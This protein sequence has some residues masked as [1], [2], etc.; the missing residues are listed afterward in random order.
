MVELHGWITFRETY[1]VFIEEE[2]HIDLLIRKIQEEINNLSWFKPKIEAQNGDWFIQFSIYA[3]RINPQILEVFE[4]CRK[5]GKIAEGSYGLIYL[6]DDEDTNGNENAFQVF[7]LA[8]GELTNK[9]D[10][11]LSP[12][13]PTIED[14]DESLEN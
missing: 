6:Y 5:I 8:R 4:L 14:K 11:Y 12:V 9:K 2:A 1:K 13:I 7:S 3:N 10:F